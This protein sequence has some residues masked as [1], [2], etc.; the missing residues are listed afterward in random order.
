VKLDVRYKLFLVLSAT[1]VTCLVVADLIGGK[2]TQLTIGGHAFTTSVGM[3]PFPVTFLLTDIINEFYGKKAARTVTLVGF[4]MAILTVVLIQV[5]LAVPFAPFTRSP[6]WAGMN[7]PSF[8]NVFRGT[9]RMFGASMAAY[10][11]GQL[12]DIGV[13]HMLKR[14]SHNRYVWLR[15]TGSTVVSQLIDTV[16]IQLGAFYGLLTL[17]QIGNQI[18][19]SYAIKLLVAVGLTPAIYAGHVFLERSFGMAPI[20]LGEDGEPEAGVE[21]PVA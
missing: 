4:G 21:E 7:E 17:P 15:A 9:W 6:D 19:T 3:V 1:F 20:R 16:C 2:L 8:D 5:A 11:V 13:F 12:L 18:V 10:L 14:W